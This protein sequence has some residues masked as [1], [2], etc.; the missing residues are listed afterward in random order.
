LFRDHEVS[1]VVQ[2]Q[3]ILIL[4][5]CK[6]LQNECSLSVLSKIKEIPGKVEGIGLSGRVFEVDV[7]KGVSRD[8]VVWDLRDELGDSDYLLVGV[9]DFHGDIA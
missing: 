8:R 7:V 4:L 2:E 1:I 5:I 6:L 3:C 9:R